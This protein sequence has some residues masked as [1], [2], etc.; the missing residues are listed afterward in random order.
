MVNRKRQFAPVWLT[1]GIGTSLTAIVST[2]LWYKQREQQSVNLYQQLDNLQITLQQSIHSNLE[3]LQ[4][5]AALYAASDEISRQEFATF[6]DGIF[7]RHPS[8]LGINW[9]RQVLA[10]ER[11]AFEQAMQAEGFAIQITQR[12][13]QGESV[14]ADARADYFPITYVEPPQEQQ[15]LGFDLG[16]EPMRRS[17][18]ERARYTG[19]MSTTG[20][21]TIVTTGQTGFLTLQPIYQRDM[22]VATVDQRRAHFSG[23]TTGV[24]Q[25]ADILK[26]ALAGLKLEHLEVYIYDRSAPAENSFLAFYGEGAGQIL[27][28]PQQEPVLDMSNRSFCQTAMACSRSLLVGDRE[29][30][31]LILPDSHYAAPHTYGA[32]IAALLAGWLLTALLATYLYASV[33]HTTQVE[34]LVQDRTMQAD[35]L[36]KTLQELQKTQSQLIQTEKMS[37]LGQLVAGVA[38]EINNPINFIHGNLSHIHNYMMDLAELVRLYQQ[39]YP[40]PVPAIAAHIEAI[41]FEFLI[42]D[43]PQLI[44]SMRLGTDRICQIV[45]SLRNF[46]RADQADIKLVNIHE[47]IDSTLL[48]LQGR[49]K[50]KANRPAINIIKNYAK[51]PLVECFAGQLNQVFMNLLSNAIDAIESHEIAKL[52]NKSAHTLNNYPCTITISTAQPKPDRISI[53]IADTG[54]GMS[55]SVRTQLY[56][57]FFTTKPVGK[58]TGLGLSISYQII[59][60]KHQGT[61]ECR[62]ELGNG[63]EFWIEIPIRQAQVN[64]Y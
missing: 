46:S 9:S 5:I 12:N 49:L 61:L 52:E 25:I 41:E 38:H 11:A 21:I 24:F 53:C 19:S 62:S 7:D 18:I 43:L 55:E 13:A 15:V 40:T 26:P 17:A 20:R 44:N 51:L 34:Q 50:A 33:R 3:S 2:N 60:E 4:T 42:N 10:D 36:R 16:S 23:V 63:T 30:T 37:S 39:Q 47:G 54:A 64:K 48:I 22:P 6:A 8:I 1:L 32:A 29:W 58:G 59:V 35:Q 27:T 28:D 45:L 14:R 57:P 56:N 31:L